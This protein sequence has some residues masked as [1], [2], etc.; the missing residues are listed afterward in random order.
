MIVKDLVM[1]S[2]IDSND[3]YKKYYS[4]NYHY[5]YLYTSDEVNE[6]LPLIEDNMDMETSMIISMGL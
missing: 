6:L 2:V 3:Y 5:K 1:N 4:Q